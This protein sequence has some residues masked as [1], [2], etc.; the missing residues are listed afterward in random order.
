VV[1]VAPAPLVVVVETRRLE[2]L[3]SILEMEVLV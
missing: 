2:A 1:V 3:M